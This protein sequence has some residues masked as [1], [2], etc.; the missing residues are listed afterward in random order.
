MTHA[1][2]GA[3]SAADFEVAII[4]NNIVVG[5]EE[6]ARIVKRDRAAGLIFENVGGTGY[7]IEQKAVSVFDI[8]DAAAEIGDTGDADLEV[9][10]IDVDR[11]AVHQRIA[12]G[13][14]RCVA[15][16]AGLQRPEVR[17]GRAEEA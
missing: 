15:G 1:T 7:L 9:G 11:A 17:Q 12:E 5:D 6:L 4:D 10:G 13:V 3:G 14:R 2:T 16:A 8:D